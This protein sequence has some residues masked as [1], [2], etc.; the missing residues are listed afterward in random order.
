MEA[1]K[2]MASFAPILY[3][4]NVADAIAFYTKAF[5]AKEL[6]RWSNDDGSVHVA[7]MMIENALFHLHEETTRKKELSPST[8]NGTCYTG[9][10][11][12]RPG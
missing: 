9:I 11:C 6:R 10:I 7:E 2:P 3:L 12:R 1:A 8:L 5:N 4:K